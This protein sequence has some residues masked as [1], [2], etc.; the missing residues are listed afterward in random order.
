MITSQ[1]QNSCAR[2]LKDLN[3][4]D[5]PIPAEPITVSIVGAGQRGSG[6]AYYAMLDSQ[7]AKVVAVA[8]PNKIRRREM[9][10]RY[11]IPD[12]NVFSDWK[13]LTNRPK[14]SDAIIIATLDNLHTEPA[15]A[16]A[17]LK[18]HIL[19]EK[20]MALCLEDC[21]KITDAA[22]RNKIILAVGHVLR[23]T[24]HN[25]LIKR[26]IDSGLLGNVINIQHL[27]P[28]GN[29]HFAHSYVRGNWRKEQDSCFSLM[30]KCCHDIDLMAHWNESPCVKISSFG[31]LSHFTSRNK[32]TEAGDAKKCL[33]CAHEPSCTYSAKR[34][35]IKQFEDGNDLW[36]VSV[37]TDIV[38][39]EHLVE[40]LKTG[41]YGRCVYEC[42]NDVADHQVV[43]MEFANGA[44][45]TVTMVA[46]TEEICTRKTRIFGSLGELE[47]DGMDSISYY[48][49]ST[50]KK[51]LLRPTDI[52]GASDLSGHGGGD[53]GLMQSFLFAIA[54]KNES[55]KFIVSGPEETF[56]SHLYVFA[57]EHSRK[58]GQVV[59]IEQ[60]KHDN[61]I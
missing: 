28:V 54:S 15:I 51:E 36:P 18:Y 60:F 13:E 8:E 37:V 25:R 1:S 6:Y 3:N 14:L 32:P 12:E 17:D 30:T 53:F 38:D 23:Y 58:T 22:I 2:I 55:T 34:I 57:A 40:A 42:D 41:P 5:P 20:P 33:D 16:F 27:E 48:N 46:F 45:A 61:G 47:C 11:N 29:W 43:N 50:E 4:K 31:N 35:Y 10:E 56:D 26:V 59:Y 21:R 19:L 49:F 39:I 24:P 7:L 9:Q 52:I 44:T